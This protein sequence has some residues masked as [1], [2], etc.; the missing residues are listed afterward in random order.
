MSSAP[1]RYEVATYGETLLIGG[2]FL[3]ILIVLYPKSILQEQVLSESRNYDLTMA[4][5][6]NMIKLEPQNDELLVRMAKLSIDRGKLDLGNELLVLLRQSDAPMLIEQRRLLEYRLLKAEKGLH[7]TLE[8]QNEIDVQMRAKMSEALQAGVNDP[9]LAK[10]WYEEASALEE[11]HAALGFLR[12]LIAL[13]EPQWLERCVYLAGSLGVYETQL[14]CVEALLLVDEARSNEW[15]RARYH[16]ALAAEH[17]E[18]ALQSALALAQSEP[19]YFDEAATLYASI[20][21]FKAASDLMLE[22]YERTGEAT[23]LL[24]AIEWLRAGER[25]DAMVALIQRHEERHLNDPSV[26]NAMMRIYLAAQRLS[27]ARL[28]AEKVLRRQP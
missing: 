11:A 7:V 25:I 26:I 1:K 22:R 21:N 20:G 17:K 3:F 5:L 13:R 27:E 18:L 12:P 2:I 16:V 9:D 4:Y 24:R 23:F 14:E 8:R 28:L 15:M 10:V 19:R 6:R